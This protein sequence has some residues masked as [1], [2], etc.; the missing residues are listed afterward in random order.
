MTNIPLEKATQYASVTADWLRPYCERIELAGSIRRRRPF[1]NDIDLVVIPKVHQHIDLFGTVT[2]MGNLLHSFLSRY[3]R[4]TPTSEWISGEKNPDG[5]MWIVK[6]KS[7]V[8]L[9]IWA[10]TPD[11]FGMILLIR[12]GSNEH[13][14]YLCERARKMNLE[15]KVGVGL[16]CDGGVIASK[17]EREIFTGLEMEWVAPGEREK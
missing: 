10:A 8:Q 6:L 3:V 7:G 13:N 15:M 17:T 9:D 14:I 16:M 4:E 12:T 5:K 2:N 11:N 1:C